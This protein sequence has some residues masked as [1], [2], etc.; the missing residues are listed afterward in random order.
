MYAIRSYYA[1]QYDKGTYMALPTDFTNA[2]ADFK[3]GDYAAGQIKTPANSYNF[4]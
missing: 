4:V 1:W 3:A 2:V